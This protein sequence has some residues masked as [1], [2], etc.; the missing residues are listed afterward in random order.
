MLHP[1]ALGLY[2]SIKVRLTNMSEMDV[3][4]NSKAYT[5]KTNK[6]DEEMVVNGLQSNGSEKALHFSASLKNTRKKR[7]MTQ[8]TH[9]RH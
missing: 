9:D 1:L 5:T 6:I 4:S 8:Y 2:R 3:T 7:M